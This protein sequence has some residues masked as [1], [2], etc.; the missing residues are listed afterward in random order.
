[1]TNRMCLRGLESQDRQRKM[2]RI[3]AS[4]GGEDNGE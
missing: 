2:N 1:M 3:W 4:L